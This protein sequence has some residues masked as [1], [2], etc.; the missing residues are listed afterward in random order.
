MTKWIL[1]GCLAVTLL[2]TAA[3]GAERAPER[4]VHGSTITSQHDPAVKIRLPK[5]AQYAGS[6]QSSPNFHANNPKSKL[7]SNS[8][9]SG[10]LP[11]SI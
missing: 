8:R 6:A 2:S 1:I 5:A 10:S 7:V 11:I 3:A 9:I 4:L